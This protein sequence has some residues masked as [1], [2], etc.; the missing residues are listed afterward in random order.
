MYGAYMT[1]SLLL[2]ALFCSAS[3]LNAQTSLVLTSENTLMTQ[4]GDT[5]GWYQINSTGMDFPATGDNQVWDY[6]AVE[7]GTNLYT[8]SYV[9]AN[10]PSFPEAT[11][12]RT[13]YY[14]LAAFQLNGMAYF[15]NTTTGE[16]YMGNSYEEASFDLNGMG[17][18]DVPA[19]SNP[20]GTGQTYLRLPAQYN[21]TWQSDIHALLNTEL[22][23][24]LMGLDHTPTV[25]DQISHFR[26]TVVGAGTLKLPGGFT[27]E[28]LLVK[29]VVT[30]VDSF[31]VAG[32]PAPPALLAALGLQQGSTSTGTQHR[33]YAAGVAGPLMTFRGSDA[34]NMWVELRDGLSTTS[35]NTPGEVTRPVQLYPNPV[36]GQEATL[37]FDKSTSGAWNIIVR[38][39]MGQ[40][41]QT[42]PVHQPAGAVTMR[43]SLDPTLANGTYFYEIRNEN[44]ERTGSGSFIVSAK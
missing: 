25:Y 23:I 44:A 35:V 1:R 29:S 13:A 18:L 9:Q 5:Q 30:I 15:Q 31:Y 4:A 21:S 28:A 16:Y 3:V 20:Y 19:Q 38:N 37:A 11:H 8:D 40:T 36:T 7:V 26:D 39:M 32:E 42:L 2:A 17:T 27:T 12:A 14:G 33:F 10:N 34:Q 43:L 41:V 6:S 24:G 22:T